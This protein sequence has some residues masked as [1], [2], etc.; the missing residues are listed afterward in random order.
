MN[1][2]IYARRSNEQNVADEAKSVTRQIDNGRA[3]AQA[4]GWTVLDEHSFSD[5][6]S[7]AEFEKRSGLQRL[8]SA[9]KPKAPF[10]ILVVAEQKAIGREMT[11]VAYIIKRLALAGVDVWGYMED[12][13]LTPRNPNDKLMSSVQGYSDEDHRVKTSARMHEAHARLAS[14][15]H[16]AGGRV[17]GYKNKIVHSGEDASGNP[18]RS[19]VERVI[20]DV[21]AAVVRRIFKMYASGLGLKAIAKQL[22]AEGAPAPNYTR[23]RDGL[24]S[25][26]GWAPSTVRSVLGR[27]LYRGVAVWGKLRRCNAW[28][29]VD[30][31]E[32][33]EAE[34]VRTPRPD[35]RV[36]SDELWHRVR[37]RRADVEGRAVRF[38]SGRLSG[39]PPKHAIKNLLAGLGSCGTCGGGLVAESGGRGA[40]YP[41]YVCHRHRHNGSCDNKLRVRV[42]EVNEA[43]LQAIEEHALTP[44]AVEQVIQLTERDDVAERRA[45]LDREAKDVE[46]R[47]KR[48]VEA[49]EAGSDAAPL[50]DRL[51][52]LEARRQG[53]AD[54]LAALRPVPRL[55]RK[56][57]EGRLAEWRRLLRQS[58]TQGRAVIQR[59]IV[60]RITFTPRADGQGYDFSAQSRMDR[61]FTGV[62]APRP[63]YLKEGNV[64]GTEHIRP[65]DTL[66]A[67][68]GRLLERACGKGLVALRGFEPEVV[69]F[70][71]RGIGRVHVATAL[72][73]TGRRVIVHDDQFTQDTKDEAWL[74]AA[75]ANGW[76]VLTKDGMIRKRPMASVTCTH[77]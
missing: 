50:V 31:A 2:A 11:E 75:G 40:R 69:F 8:L 44:E 54:E 55:P 68:Y 77:P 30:W 19:H 39:R 47:V 56:V 28:G 26:K 52:Q 12:R 41:Q 72:R 62:A 22:T 42:E 24:V 74:T 60:G 73:E 38:D 7:G 36:V 61:L 64:R 21:E 65:E 3:F 20:N 53:I 10:Q 13:C 48:L 1:A 35:L 18:L 15:G 51:R 33:P 6:G 71:D 9:L 4:H 49:I 17:F 76:V 14:K 34:W 66:D 59:V 46:K 43:V 67:D 29:A 57:V 58:T 63:T 23:P 27:E 37:S 45:R 5:T 32:R 70:V 16:V 25:I